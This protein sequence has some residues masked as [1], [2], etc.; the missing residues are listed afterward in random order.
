MKAT[1]TSRQHWVTKHVSGFCGTGKMM[2]RWK[3]R[4]TAKCPRCTEDKDAEHVWVCQGQGANEVWDKSIL[5]LK[6]WMKTQKTQPDLATAICSRLSHW[7]YKTIP[8]DSL[9]SASIREMLNEQDK[10][11]WKAVLEGTLIRGWREAQQEQLTR[12]GSR[13][14]GLRWVTALIQKL[15]DVAWDQWQHRNGVLHEKDSAILLTEVDGAIKDQWAKGT[16]EITEDGKIMLRMGLRKVL[17]LSL[18][19]KEGWLI[20]VRAARCRYYLRAEQQAGTYARERN[21]MAQWLAQQNPR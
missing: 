20:R 7:R 14:T 16:R 12:T 17:A 18:E 9:Y 8:D 11:G 10:F 5:A 13:R 1:K 15:W 4:E 19:L 3:K 21:V 6:E 2:A